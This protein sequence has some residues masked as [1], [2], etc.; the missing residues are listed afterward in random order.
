M[1]IGCSDG[2]R[3][4]NISTNLSIEK[5]GKKQTD[6]SHQDMKSI[7]ST[8]TR[9]TTDLRICVSC[10]AGITEAFTNGNTKLAKNGSQPMQQERGRVVGRWP[11]N[12]IHDGSEEV[13]KG[14]PDAPGQ[15]YATCPQYDR[16]AN[17]Y[18]KFAGVTLAEP[19]GDEGSAARFFYTAKAD[20]VDRIGSRHPTVKPLDL[21]QYLVRLVTPKGGLVLDCFAGTGTTGEAAFRE[22]FRAILIER[23]AEYLKDIE[24]RIALCMAGPVERAN[25]AMKAKLNGKPRDDGPLFAQ[26]WDDMW[27][28]PFD[29]PELL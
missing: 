5:S 14:F 24:R 12:V 8:E 16:N 20:Q 27:A 18:G 26:T 6:Q 4:E 13:V 25:A 21:M 1:D 19:R 22:G 9:A 11:G 28:K 10:G 15:Q 2:T 3:P 23:E 7:I 17:V 29:R